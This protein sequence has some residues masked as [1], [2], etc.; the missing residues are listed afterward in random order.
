MRAK[1]REYVRYGRRESLASLRTKV[2]N[3]EQQL[4]G[5]YKGH[6][7]RWIGRDLPHFLLVEARCVPRK[8]LGYIL[9]QMMLINQGLNVNIRIVSR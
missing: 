9:R 5:L 8:I 7:L 6:V 3:I 4:Q 1:N 2:R